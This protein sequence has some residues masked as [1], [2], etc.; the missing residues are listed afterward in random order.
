MS[1][2]GLGIS[3]VICTYNGSGR[4]RLTIDAVLKQRLHDSLFELVIVDNASQDDTREFCVQYLSGSPAAFNWKVIEEEKPGLNNARICGLRESK[5][6]VVLFCDDDNILE[7]DYLEVAYELLKNNPQIGVLGGC[8]IPLFEKSKPEWFDKYSHSFA[9]G[10]QAKVDGKLMQVPAHLYGAGSFFRK[11]PLLKLFA[12]GFTTIM[13]DR[14]G[15]SLTSGGDVEWCYL[16]QLAGYEIW[17]DHHLT[18][19]HLM[20]ES[21]MQW[22]YYL[23]L[24]AGIGAGEGLLLP[25]KYRFMNYNMSLFAYIGHWF[26][27]SLF[28]SVVYVK[29]KF[30]QLLSPTIRRPM[31][32]LSKVLLH[33]KM[34]S[35]WKN[36]LKSLNH[37]RQLKKFM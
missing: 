7:A 9:V 33:A 2:S 14:N 6:E 24:K 10:P 19:L 18:F 13:S 16:M 8:G 5:F 31:D 11:D 1:H 21:R 30:L 23:R 20:P 17:Y 12:R 27:Q 25:Y 34:I 26:F 29:H 15:A 28:C 4:L 22:S 3:V 32:E 36:G 37:F 35:Y